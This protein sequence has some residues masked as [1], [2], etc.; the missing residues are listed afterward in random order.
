MAEFS[1]LFFQ[2]DYLCL[3]IGRIN[4]SYYASHIFAQISLI[5]VSMCVISILIFSVLFSPFSLKNLLMTWSSFYFS[6]LFPL[7]DLKFENSI[8]IPLVVYLKF[9][10]WITLFNRNTSESLSILLL[11]IKVLY[12]LY[13]NSSLLIS[14]CFPVF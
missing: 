2:C 4:Y 10:T 7:T 6:L 13:S 11:N 9:L 8:S 5:F 3:F 1:F 14:Y 12:C